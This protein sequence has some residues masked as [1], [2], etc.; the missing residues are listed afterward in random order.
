MSGHHRRLPGAALSALFEHS[1]DA[2]LYGSP[3]GTVIAANPAACALLRLSEDQIC[4]RSR[5]GLADPADA[6][7]PGAVHERDETGRLHAELR[8]V[9]GDGDVFLADVASVAFT[10]TK[11]DPRV[12]VTLRDAGQHQA[13]ALFEA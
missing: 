12:V 4:R 8:M 11:G 9:R 5:D 10:D 6:R 3:D 7:W 13:F 2:M 1:P